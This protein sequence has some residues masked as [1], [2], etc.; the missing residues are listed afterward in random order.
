MHVSLLRGEK[1]EGR[2]SAPGNAYCEEYV[3]AIILLRFFMLRF[4]SPSDLDFVE[5][6]QPFQLLTLGRSCADGTGHESVAVHHQTCARRASSKKIA[7]RGLLAG[8]TITD[9]SPKLPRT[10]FYHHTTMMKS[11]SR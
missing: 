10:L 8:I 9:S 2:P 11:K 6:L 7:K 4:L 3:L 1:A 5:S